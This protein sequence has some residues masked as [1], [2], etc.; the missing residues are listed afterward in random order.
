MG[1]KPGAVFEKYQMRPTDAFVNTPHT[2]KGNP[3]GASYR[4]STYSN[5]AKGVFAVPAVGSHVWVLFMDGTINYPVYIGAVISNGDF[6]SIFQTEDG[7]IQDYPG[8]FENRGTNV[9]P[10]ED[11]NNQTYRNKMVINQRG[12]AL[13]IINTTDRESFK[14]T[15]FG[16]G[17]IEL[18]NFFNA[19]FSPKNLQYLTLKD[20]FETVKGHSSSYV[21]RDFE[22]IIKGN[23]V[24][25]V[26]SLNKAAIDE[27][28]SA[29]T[30]IADLL[31]LP[32]GAG[33]KNNLASV[34]QQQ[35]D[36]LAAA[37]AKLGFGGNFI[38]TVT[39]HKFLN[40]GLTFNTFASTRVNQT[41]KEVARFRNVIS[42]GTELVT[43]DIDLIEYTHIDDMPGGNY[44]QTIGNRYNLLVGSGGI[45]AKTTG[46]VNLGGTIMVFAGTQMNIASELDTNIDGGTNLSI[47]ADI[48]AIRT[49]SRQQVVVDDNLGV[50]KN[51]VIGGG[52]H[53]NGNL[54]IHHI[55]APYE[56]QSTELTKQ[57]AGTG[58]WNI[59][60]A[61]GTITLSNMSSVNTL[62]PNWTS[63]GNIAVSLNTG[64]LTID[65]PH[66]H[67]FKNVP[68]T[69]L[70]N[71]TAVRDAAAP[72]VNAGTSAAS[73]SNT[74]QNYN[75]PDYYSPSQGAHSAYNG[76]GTTIRS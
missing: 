3:Y 32:E 48:M 12:A 73:A 34:V 10:T 14:V 5:S 4:P 35:A 22:N 9:K 20:K 7:A 16:G 63:T 43:A 38:E 69:L 60:T 1:E 36:A 59:A 50:S 28:V 68:L 41:P 44:T 17:F 11:D 71:S 29:Y 61:T 26:G 23:H 53:I 19:V 39:K 24:L 56:F 31:S 6:K 55:T 13:E 45:D 37:E 64:T 25:N 2:V 49:R 74:N 67:A 70:A 51:V 66:N 47:I 40:V 58:E 42:S 15:H 65:K 52:M 8:S 57:Q 18:N 30:A 76:P 62:N 54:Y 72:V 33:S 75:A 27:W 46:P 21:G